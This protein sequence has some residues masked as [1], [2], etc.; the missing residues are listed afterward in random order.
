[1]EAQKRRNM[2]GYGSGRKRQVDLERYKGWKERVGSELKEV[3]MTWAGKEVGKGL[4]KDGS[5]EETEI[6]G[7]RQARGGRA[8]IL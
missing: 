8:G 4:R 7:E 6:D 2:N 3:S 1:M 5:T